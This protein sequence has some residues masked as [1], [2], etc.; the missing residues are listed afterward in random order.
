MASILTNA[1]AL[2]ALR[3]LANTQNALNKT[4]GQ[5]STGLKVA[6]ASDNTTNWSVSTQIKTDN[7]VINTIKDTL[8]QNSDL[9]NTASSAMD[10]LIATIDKIKVEL[11]KAKDVKD[12]NFDAINTSLAKLGAEL[13]GVLENAALNGVNLLDNS[14]SDMDAGA[15]GN[16]IKLAAGWSGGTTGSGFKTINVNLT[17]LGGVAAGAGTGVLNKAGA[18]TLAVNAINITGT[19]ATAQTLVDTVAG[20]VETALESVRNFATELGAAKN[21]IDAQSKFL[22]ALG[23]AMTNSVSTLVDADMNEAS[24]RLQAL[25]TQ[26]QLGVQSLSIANQNSQM[27]LKLFQ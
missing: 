12:D 10:N 23:E 16:Q 8:K 7:S 27:I 20:E 4:Q 1:S 13:D 14:V 19:G 26:Q 18:S 5:I 3:N 6:S 17:D 24:T 25:Q 21:Q 2:T 9:L 11:A 15:A 22:S